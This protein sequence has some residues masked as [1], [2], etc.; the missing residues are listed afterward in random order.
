MG[1]RCWFL[2][3]SWRAHIALQLSLIQ[4]LLIPH[5]LGVMETQSWLIR[6]PEP[7]VRRAVSGRP[8][9]ATPATRWPYT[10][11]GWASQASAWTRGPRPCCCTTT[12][13]LLLCLTSRSFSFIAE[14]HHSRRE[15]RRARTHPSPLHFQIDHANSSTLLRSTTSTRYCSRSNPSEATF[16]VT[17]TTMATVRHRARVRPWPETT[18]APPLSLSLIW[19]SP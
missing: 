7:A 12:R 10:G 17:I 15:L 1:I 8:R 16:R 4:F 5:G 3:Q 19:C 6:R 9:Q 2:N 13:A 14:Q 18:R 11:D